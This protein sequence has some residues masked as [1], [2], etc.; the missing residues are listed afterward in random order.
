MPPYGVSLWNVKFLLPYKMAPLK[1]PGPNGML[2]LFN[3]HF[4]EIM[5]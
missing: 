3:Q 2:P 1:V 5:D 4:W